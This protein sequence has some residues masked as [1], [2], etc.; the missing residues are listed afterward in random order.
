MSA[1]GAVVVE[2][3]PDASEFD[4]VRQRKTY[5]P[6]MPKCILLLSLDGRNKEFS[7]HGRLFG[8][9]DSLSFGLAAWFRA[10]KM[11]PDRSDEGVAH[12]NDGVGLAA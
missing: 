11:G 6:P 2:T 12:E 4:Q 7:T 10:G 5:A 1:L 8:R 9:D 3:G